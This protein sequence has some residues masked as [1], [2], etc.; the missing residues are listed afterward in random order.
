[1]YSYVDKYIKDNIIE[2]TDELKLASLNKVLFATFSTLLQLLLIL[3]KNREYNES[4]FRQIQVLFSK[5]YKD[6]LHM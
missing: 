2:K 3:K 4:F 6:L 5:T 1:M